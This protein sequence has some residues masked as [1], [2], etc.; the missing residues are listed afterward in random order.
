MK[1]YVANC[2]KQVQDFVY[3]SI[4][5]ATPR[6]VRIDIGSQQQLPGAWNT[7]DVQYLEEQ[8]RR[9]GLIPVAEVNRTRDFIGVCYSIDKPVDIDRIRI[10]LVNNDEVLTERGRV[11]RQHAAVAAADSIEQGGQPGMLRSLEMSVQ[12]EPKDG[13][14]PAVNEGTRVS[15]TQGAPQAP[16][17]SGR[18]TRRRA[19]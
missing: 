3:R 18:S 4:G 2:T 11:L 14:M 12:E 1:I 8:H 17:P 9:Y 16:Q 7:E 10:A 5:A 13:G 19:A 15:R 6:M